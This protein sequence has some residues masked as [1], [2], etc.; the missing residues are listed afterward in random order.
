MP[1]EL[2]KQLKQMRIDIIEER[3]K[4]KKTWVIYSEKPLDRLL[5]KYDAEYNM[6]EVEDSGWEE[7]WKNYLEEGWLTDSVYYCFDDKT[8]DDGREVIRINPAL[9]FG[10]GS[11]P[12]TKLAARLLEKVS[13]GAK[14]L[15]VGTGSA[16]LAILASLKG[17]KCVY[18]CD[19][20]EV[21]TVNA[22]DNIKRN[23]CSNIYVWAGGITSVST[24]L[25]PSVVVANIISSELVKLHPHI[26]TLNPKHIIYSGILQKECSDFINTV[27]T[28]GYEP[29]EVINMEGWMGIRFKK[30]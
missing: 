17:A 30:L 22:H 16:I 15:D 21:S 3:F 29:D 20:D 13:K 27:K 1:A 11:H 23:D 8:F 12:T 28:N 25:N 26:L 10:T 19:I 9:A 2:K 18:A 24:K 14:V 5:N 4:R 7:F 6:I